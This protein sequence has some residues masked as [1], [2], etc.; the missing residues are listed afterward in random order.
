[1]DKTCIIS[2]IFFSPPEKSTLTSLSSSSSITSL[3]LTFLIK[4]SR[5]ILD[6]F[7]RSS[8]SFTFLTAGGS[9][10]TIETPSLAL[11]SIGR[12][13]TSLPL[14]NI[15]P[16]TTLYFGKPTITLANVDFPAAFGPRRACTVPF[17]I[18]R[19]MF[20]NITLLP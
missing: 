2:E 15:E 8:L 13:V 11:S 7:W 6:I 18:F 4:L 20:F 9:W 12:F 16:V 10:K 1:M 17:S 3:N 19:F 5:G 14:K